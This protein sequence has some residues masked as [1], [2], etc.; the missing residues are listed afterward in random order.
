MRPCPS[1]EELQQLLAEQLR[2]PAREAIEGHVEACAACQGVLARLTDQAGTNDWRYLLRCPPPSVSESDADIARYLKE[3]PPGDTE[4]GPEEGAGPGPL[5]IPGPPT[6]KGPLG[7]LDS[8]HLR[9]ELGRGR[10]GIVFQAVDELDR[11]VAVKVL[12][13]ELA[14]DPRERARFQAEARKAAAVRHDH[15]VIVH[16]VGHASGVALPYLVMEYVEG[17]ALAARLRRAGVLPPRE[18]ASVVRQVAL[19][20]A[21]AHARGLVH[22]DVKPSNILLEAGSGRAKVT[23]FGLARATEAG[24]TASQL[25]AVVG[26]PAYMSPEQVTAPGKVDGRSDVYS[27]GVVLYEALTGEQPFRGVPHLVLDQVVHEEP[28]R[29]RKLNDAVPRDLETITLRCLAKEP[30]RRYQTA[31]ALAEDLQRWLDGRPIQARPIG[32]LECGWRWCRRN[33]GLAGAVGAATLFLV[34]GSIISSL[35]AVRAFGEARRADREAASARANEQL[36]REAKRL[37]DRRYYASEMKL[38]SLD[39]EASQPGLVQQRLQKFERQDAGEPDLR[40]FEWYYLQRLCRLELRT[41]QGH[42]GPVWGVAFSPDG[43]RLASASQDGAVRL[44]DA[45]AGQKL[46]TIKGHTGAVLG[47]AFSPDGKHLASASEDQTV[48]VWDAATGQVIHTLEGPRGEVSG[49]AFSPTNGRWLASAH[50]D[51]TVRVWDTA[52]GHEIGTLKGHTGRV[53]GV[54]FSPD[55]K[56]LASAS[57]DQTVKVW[58]TATGHE[59][60]SLKGHTNEVRSLAFSPDGKQ[61]ASASWDQTVKVWDAA[62]GH[63]IRTLKGHT[64]GVYGVAFGPDGRQLASASRDQTV[65]VWDLAAGQESLTLRGHRDSVWGV[66]FSPDGRRLASASQDG[67]VRVWDAATRPRTFTFKGHPAAVLGVAFSP[68]G[69]RLASASWD[70]TVKVWDAGTG[71]ETLSLQGPTGGFEGV[72]FSPDGKQLASASNDFIVGVWDAASGQKLRTLEGHTD[73]VF[74]V[75]F[76]PDG[77]RLASTSRDGTVRVWDAATGRETLTLLGSTGE[78]TVAPFSPAFSPDG[79]RLASASGDKGVKVWDTATGQE[80]LTCEGH[81][82]RVFGVAFSPDG[83]HLASASWDQ[84]VKVWDAATGQE[85]LSLQGHTGWVVGVAFS[86]DGRRLAS[87]SRDG[88]V[89][90]WDA[91]TGQ[92]TLTLQGH[93]GAVWGVAFSPKD[94]RRLASASG[95]GTAKVWDARELTPERLIEGEARGLV[96]FLFAKPLPPG[97]VAAAVRRDPTITEPVRQQALAWVEPCWR[98]QVRAEAARVV[99]PLFAKPLRRREVL[100][101]LRAG[102]SLS[103]P[104]RQE[105]LMLA[106]T[107]PEDAYALNTA[108]W[109]VVRRPGAD[110]S[111]YRRALGQAETASGLAPNNAIHLNTLGV[112]YYRVGRYQEAIHTLGRSANLRKELPPDLAFLAMSQHQLGQKKQAR[113]TLARLREAMKQTRWA[114]DAEAQGFLREAEEVLKTKPAGGKRP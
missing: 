105:A 55:G 26:T 99:G 77:R 64:Y 73:R 40:G 69:R 1:H 6:T 67:M 37:S 13:P 85:T 103:S 31:A 98:I 43:R 56:H 61:L 44:W 11:L 3:N 63:E 66:A 72:A 46:L 53:L 33:P 76:S 81:T 28:R 113:D 7:R 10:Y 27:L 68:D 5:A 86:P 110:A 58:D 2:P 102:A 14:A 95:D 112:A 47:V 100:A 4:L 45:A 82:G 30:G 111:A 84:T 12:R 108:S 39:W 60:R 48:K 41:L 17:E 106:E 92:E 109:A 49:V 16:Q 87:T 22:R 35:L 19:G 34:L 9:R 32:V 90:V 89:R 24:A 65:K 104:V 78:S 96:Q 101:T 75:A 36:V 51:Q 93:T 88:T 20:V 79:H 18:A 57:G 114:K 94:G 42:T 83:K 54:A 62:T 15:I 50:A 80:I 70:R 91:A 97:E 29:P 21:A 59:I 71:Q 107:F 52:T 74:G 38:A 8:L 23:D 25:G